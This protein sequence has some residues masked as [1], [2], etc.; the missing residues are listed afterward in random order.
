MA[1]SRRMQ[2]T[3]TASSL[4]IA[5]LILLVTAT[6]VS[7]TPLTLPDAIGRALR[8]APSVTMAAAASD[9]SE[10]RIR[11]MRAPFLP[12]V[13][14]NTE[15]YQA[16][17]YAEVITNRGLSSAMLTLNWTAFDFGRRL[18]RLNSARYASEAARLGITAAQAQIVFD[19]KVA[20]FD[21]VR[22]NRA[23][24][25]LQS[26]LERLTRYVGT[27]ETLVGSGRAVMNDL[28]KV[29]SAR[30]GAELTLA[31]AQSQKR[32]AAIALGSLIG[33]FDHFDFEVP[34]PAP[35]GPIPAGDLARTPTLRAAERAVSAAA[36][37]VKAAETE[38]YPT[39]QFAL[40]SGFLGVDPPSTV[41]H[42]LGASY[43]GLVSVPI[44]QGGLVASH[45][46]AAKARKRQAMAQARQAEYLLRR[47][48]DDATVRY[49][50]SLEALRI[51]DRSQPTADD[52]FALTWARF[53]G[54]GNVTLLE[55]MAAYEQAE[56][57]RLS[58]FDQEFAAREAAAEAALLL[59]W[60]K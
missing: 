6:R 16:P 42:H 10:A 19:T 34:E 51:L 38:R 28:L 55:V 54:G 11:E 15:Y 47:R 12:T 39:L 1:L 37:Q 36:M 2:A 45:I 7:A 33:E 14:A 5:S 3:A 24:A 4:A 9:L 31:E 8:F 46:D 48:L 25:E 41:D 27:V 40:T 23:V 17:G 32:R 20:Y 56:S 53:L 30:D 50:K 29:R 22:A 43:D 58:R 59:G 13:A 44:F 21:L 57:L 35:I 60:T 49:R 26:N 52:A 18:A